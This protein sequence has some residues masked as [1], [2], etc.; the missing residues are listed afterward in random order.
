[1]YIF[2]VVALEKRIY[3]CGDGQN[4]NLS[5]FRTPLTGYIT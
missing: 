2:V 1:M 5:R 4:P 3:L